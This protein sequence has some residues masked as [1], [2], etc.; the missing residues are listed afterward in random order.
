MKTTITTAQYLEA[1]EHALKTEGLK[2]ADIMNK[3][4]LE[5][6]AITLDQYRMAARLLADA[7]LATR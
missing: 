7:Y 3:L 5:M 1:I 6:E 4:A 2:V